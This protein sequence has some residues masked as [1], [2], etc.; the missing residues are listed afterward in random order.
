MQLFQ[1]EWDEC[2]EM[3]AGVL[4][5]CWNIFSFDHFFFFDHIGTFFTFFC[6][7]TNNFI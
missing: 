5:E 7:D 1:E 3:K 2:N 4:Q 6:F